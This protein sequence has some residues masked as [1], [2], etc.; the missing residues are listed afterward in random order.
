LKHNRNYTGDLSQQ[1]PGVYEL[2]AKIIDLTYITFQK[3]PEIIVVP[4]FKILERLP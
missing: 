2:Y 4:K 3:R 1:N